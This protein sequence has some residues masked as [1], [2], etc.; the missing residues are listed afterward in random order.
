[1]TSIPTLHIWHD[2]V[3]PFS[4]IA[5]TR[6]MRIKRSDGLDLDIRFHPWP[7]EAA[8]GAQPRAEE[9]D[10]WVRLLRSVE[11]D[12]FA[13]WDPSSPF[14]PSSSG[15]LFAAYEAALAQDVT[16]AERFDLVLRQAI[17]Q[18]PR[19]VDSIEAVTELAS[20]AGLDVAAFRGLVADGSAGRRAEEARSGAQTLGIRGIPTLVLPDGEKAINPGLT[21]ERTE[22]GR[23]IRDDF[24]TLRVLLRQAAEAA[25]AGSAHGW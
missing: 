1:M 21:I 4:Y 10:Q 18:H 15:L 3:C 2:Y 16:A 11:P 6:I 17:F 13:Q 9:E 20:A 8:N 12:A 22:Q 19:P 24:E 23:V 5:A 25:P 7:L 14:W